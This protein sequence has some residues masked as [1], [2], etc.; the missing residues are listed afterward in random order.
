MSA[1][2]T[3]ATLFEKSGR[4]A[5]LGRYTP[6]PAGSAPAE[7]LG[8]WAADLLREDAPPLPELGELDVVRHYTHLAGRNFSLDA[9]F[10]P[11]GS[12]TMK[13]NPRVN[14]WAAGQE[15]LAGLHPLTPTAAAQGALRLMYELQEFLAEIAG[16]PVVS[17]APAAGAHGELTALK[18]IM[19]YHAGRGRRR[20]KVLTPDSS[21]GTNPASCTLCG[22][23]A[24]GVKS[25]RDGRI[26]LDDLGAKLDDDTA[27]LMITN[28][29]TLGLFERDIVA[30]AE[31]T[32]AA[33]AQV[34]LDGANM[35][36]ILGLARPGDFGVDAM[37]FNLHKTF[38]TPHGGG[39][40][41]AGPVAVAEHLAPFLPVPMVLKKGDVYDL[42]TDR[43]ENIGR[44]RS[45]AGQFGTFVRAWCYIRACGPDGLANVSR[46]AVLSA[47]YLAAA[48]RG[49]LPL[50]YEGPCMHEFVLSAQRA[51]GTQMRKP[52]CRLCRRT[53]RSANALPFGET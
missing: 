13:Y 45:F 31:R 48:L 34:Y 53:I 20:T 17:L 8:Q 5:N 19:A 40:P 3:V 43:P 51:G 21:H 39:G 27:A 4:G 35:N 49:V 50:A 15:A 38:S 32:H 47:N 11:L 10:Y 14:E 41:G 33:G 36:A 6:A 30:V 9:N 22:R 37:H 29:N 44:M 28:P 42:Q 18:A 12:C 2:S 1:R 26:D 52:S 46:T 23:S 7:L 16:L 25:R 24:V